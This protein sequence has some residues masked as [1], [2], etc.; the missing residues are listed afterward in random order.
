MRVRSEATSMRF[1]AELGGVVVS[2]LVFSLFV[3]PIGMCED[4]A[5]PAEDEIEVLP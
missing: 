2:H 5:E 4:V 1:V 3:V